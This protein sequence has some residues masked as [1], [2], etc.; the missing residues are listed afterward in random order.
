MEEDLRRR[1]ARA[2]ARKIDT[3]VCFRI[4]GCN[5]EAEA[6]V[7]EI[8]EEIATILKKITDEMEQGR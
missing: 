6:T 2:L 8:E 1:L 5:E 7:Y 3:P 4:A